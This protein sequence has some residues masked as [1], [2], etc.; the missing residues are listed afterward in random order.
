M[1][2]DLAI[3]L[4]KKKQLQKEGKEKVIAIKELCPLVIKAFFERLED[5][6]SDLIEEKIISTS[7]EVL[8]INK[9]NL[10]NYKSKIFKLKT[11]EYEIDFI[12]KERFAVGTTGKIEMK[13][14][15]CNICF[16][17]DIDGIWKQVISKSPLSLE[18]LTRSHFR[19][20]LKS[21]LSL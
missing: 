8:T 1:D 7:Y 18:I 11:G 21:V 6:L 19:E 20:L 2:D 17:R 5:W 12:P 9:K 16:I 13:T 4:R 3:F 10:V 15:K 14:N